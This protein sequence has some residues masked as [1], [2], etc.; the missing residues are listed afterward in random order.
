M[1][2]SWLRRIADFID[3]PPM[4]A[5]AKR[6]VAQAIERECLERIQNIT[7]PRSYADE[8]QALINERN[9]EIDAE[10]AAEYRPTTYSRKL[11]AVR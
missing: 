6:V 2:A 9:A 1:L 7:P 10:I 4:S 8:V 11:R 5:E 3:P